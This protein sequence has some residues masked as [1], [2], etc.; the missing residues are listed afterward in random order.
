MPEPMSSCGIRTGAPRP[1]STPSSMGRK[2]IIRLLMAHGADTKGGLAVA[3]KGAGCGS[4]EFPGL[5]SRREYAA[6]VAL[7]GE[8]LAPPGSSVDPGTDR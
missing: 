1:S 4:E 2:R 8:W 5:P 7:L 3:L 6:V